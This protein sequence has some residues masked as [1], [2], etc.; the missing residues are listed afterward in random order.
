MNLNFG[1]NICIT[2]L[3]LRD[4]LQ[5][6]AV[7]FSVYAEDRQLGVSVTS[8]SAFT[9]E[10]GSISFSGLSENSAVLSF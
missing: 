7:D 9:T 10:I 1:M 8:S 5:L 4:Q 6:R 2:A 3:F